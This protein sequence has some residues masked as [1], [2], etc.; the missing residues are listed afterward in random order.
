MCHEFLSEEEIDRLLSAYN[1]ERSINLNQ[2]KTEILPKDI[3]KVPK[4][5]EDSLFLAINPLANRLIGTVR[6]VRAY[7]LTSDFMEQHNNSEDI[8]E[9]EAILTCLFMESKEGVINT[10]KLLIAG[11]ECVSSIKEVLQKALVIHEILLTKIKEELC[12]L[13]EQND[14]LN[15]Q[16]DSICA[17]ISEHIK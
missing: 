10:L 15:A 8:G 11:A 4:N 13:Q 17:L 3:N 6:E 16:R 7:L 14:Y 1:T 2:N 12:Q 5:E 9:L